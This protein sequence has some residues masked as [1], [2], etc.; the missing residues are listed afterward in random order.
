MQVKFEYPQRVLFAMPPTS[1]TPTLELPSGG[2]CSYT[3][4][5]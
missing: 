4:I 1:L 2:D 3:T 5:S